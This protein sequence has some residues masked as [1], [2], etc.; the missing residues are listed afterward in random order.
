MLSGPESNRSFH[1]NIASVHRQPW[2]MRAQ[3]LIL[4]ATWI[5]NSD[6]IS[7]KEHIVEPPRGYD[8]L[9]EDYKST[10]I[11]NY[12]KVATIVT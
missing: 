3:L 10:V 11:A 9:F 2:N 7:I 12:T 5:V 8:P 6:V 4:S 1:T